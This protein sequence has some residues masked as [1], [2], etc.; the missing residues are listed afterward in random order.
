MKGAIGG[1]DLTDAEK[2]AI[3]GENAARLLG[4]G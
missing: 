2:A 3:F 4:L 1:L